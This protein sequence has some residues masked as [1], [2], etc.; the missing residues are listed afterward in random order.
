MMTTRFGD[1]LWMLWIADFM[2]CVDQGVLAVGLERNVEVGCVAGRRTETL[3]AGRDGA[4]HMLYRS[5]HITAWGVLRSAMSTDER[6][7]SAER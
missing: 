2:E 1:A 5:P 7:E 3:P 6:K 4:P